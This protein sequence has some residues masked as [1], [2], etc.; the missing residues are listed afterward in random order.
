MYRGLMQEVCF[1]SL[2]YRR[3]G[4]GGLRGIERGEQ[5]RRKR[6]GQWVVE[7]EG[8]EGKGEIWKEECE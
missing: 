3:D 6:E 4:G 5:G 7:R 1:V 8:R 2:W